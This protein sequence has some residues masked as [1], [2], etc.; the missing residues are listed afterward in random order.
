MRL[1]YFI[2]LLLLT[3]CSSKKSVLYMQDLNE[4]SKFIND[5][6]VYKTK[7]DD[8]LKIDITSEDIE[9]SMIFNKPSSSSI[10]NNFESMTLD[11]Y[12]INSEGYINFPYFGKLMVL[13]KTVDEIINLLYNKI[14]EE[15]IL[16]NPSID[17]KLLNSY[18]TILGEVK[19]P[20][21][22]D[23]LE[24]NLNILEA[25]GISGDLTINGKRNDVKIIRELND[26]KIILS[27]DLTKSQFL[28]EDSFQIFSGDIIIVNPNI[29]RV[30]DAGIIGNSGTL[31]SL[32]SFIL[33]S[34]IVISNN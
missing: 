9:A 16:K 4:G 5:Y 3:N 8:I 24:N 15:S 28:N 22:Y 13:D 7:V 31:I 17:V 10:N 30:K 12:Q 14:T 34:I 19:N 26:E 20:G 11:G 27:A 18:F 23:Y 33:S 6:L 32:L 21:R 1:F 25:I 2:L 29:T